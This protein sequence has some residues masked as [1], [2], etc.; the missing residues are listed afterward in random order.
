M[1]K[2]NLSLEQ[3]GKLFQPTGYFLLLN[4]DMDIRRVTNIQCYLFLFKKSMGIDT[5]I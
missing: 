4:T 2:C 5:Y 3:S 1:A